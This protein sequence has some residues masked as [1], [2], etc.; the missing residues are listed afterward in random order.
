MSQ[1][2][3]QKQTSNTQSTLSS[4]FPEKERY[5]R[6]R[7]MKG[8]IFILISAFIMS[9]QNIIT[10]V[11]LSKQTILG[12]WE[13]GSFIS[14][15]LG[16]SILILVVRML[17][18]LPVLAF[19]VSPR[20]Y[21]NTWVDIKNLLLPDNKNRLIVSLSSG[22][23]LFVSSFSIY[24][25]LGSIPTGVATTIFFIYPTV[26]IIIL[27]IFFKEKPAV[28]LVFAMITIYLGGFLTI[29]EASFTSKGGDVLFGALAAAISGA[30]FA[31]Y[32]IMVR[33][34]K[35]HPAPFS[36]VNFTIILILGSAILP[37]FEFEIPDS[38]FLE[39]IIG[40]VLL[41]TTTLFGYLLNNFGVP[42]IGPA[43]TSV[44]GASGP[45]LTA[46]LALTLINEKLNLH[47]VIGVFLVT[48]WVIGISIENMKKQAVANQ[49]QTPDKK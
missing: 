34:S 43:L 49:S 17:I 46:I 45:A 35:M 12:I 11:I 25:A 14:P 27:W 10:R 23:L 33:L 16:N 37:F 39:L 32:V 8:V 6:P 19:L 20:I 24:L 31:G 40:C 29:P 21:K 7:F 38:T 47:Q 42:L 13:T 2:K 30:T 22:V 1:T 3:Y 28:S 36:I 26:T 5:A 15:S 9:L 44:I 41:A 18:A 48:I 4:P